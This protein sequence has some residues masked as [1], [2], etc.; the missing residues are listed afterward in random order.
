MVHRATENMGPA[1]VMTK[2]THG[3]QFVNERKQLT[4]WE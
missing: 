3:A 4:N 2:P 1:N